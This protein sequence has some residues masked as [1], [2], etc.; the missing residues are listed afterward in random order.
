M[1]IDVDLFVNHKMLYV[2]SIIDAMSPWDRAPRALGIRALCSVDPCETGILRLTHS[3][4][5]GGGFARSFLRFLD[6]YTSSQ[7]IAYG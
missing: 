4:E 2:F 7:R 3:L 5:L 1:L 6:R